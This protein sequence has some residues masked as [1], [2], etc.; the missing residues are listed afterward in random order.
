MLI[1]H[2]WISILAAA[3]ESPTQLAVPAAEAVGVAERVGIEALGSLPVQLAA[4][5]AILVFSIVIDR[6][7]LRIGIPGA[8][9]LFGAGVAIQPMSNEAFDHKG[10]EDLHVIALCLLLF[11]SGVKICRRYFRLQE[12]VVPSLLISVFGVFIVIAVG[13]LVM[14]YALSLVNAEYISSE[15]PLL[16]AL[17]LAYCIAPLDWGAFAF[18]V[19]RVDRFSDRVMG[20]LEFETAISAAIT[21]VIGQALFQFFTDQGTS[22][23]ASK[24]VDIFVGSVSQGIVI[25]AVLGYLLAATIK[26]FAVERSQS[27]DL[28]IGFVMIGYGFNTWI[29]QGGLVCSL[30]MGFVVSILLSGKESQDEK[31]I[32]SVQ[33][34]SINIAS[35]S[36]IFFMAGLAVDL[37]VGFVPTIFAACILLLLV[38]VLRPLT[39]NLF[40]KGSDFL[41][42]RERQFL[43]LWAPKGAISMALAITIPDLIEESGIPFERVIHPVS[44]SFI[45][46][47]VCF[48]V[49]LSM[50][51]KSLILPSLHR[52]MLS[53]QQPTS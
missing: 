24:A 15:Q 7:A 45:V 19:K 33:L 10:F 37:S 8:L 9:A 31:D 3:A 49:V 42:K 30:V 17:A 28:A 23:M 12:F 13:S 38:W 51:I 40:F 22:T 35:E 21:L 50:L 4:I 43:S 16:I 11:Y 6:Y 52:R 29:G 25:G 20:V 18:I 32:L 36:L 39:V 53:A 2:T 48:T 46:D 26:R 5:G 34:E 44:E 41:D 27:I 14:Y 47:A 1:P